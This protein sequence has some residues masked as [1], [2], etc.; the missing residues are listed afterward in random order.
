MLPKL[1]DTPTS[2]IPTNDAARLTAL[3]GRTTPPATTV[4]QEAEAIMG[5]IN[6]FAAT[7]L[8]RV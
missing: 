6:Q 1:P 4:A 7:T 5:I 3:A 2:L 8:K